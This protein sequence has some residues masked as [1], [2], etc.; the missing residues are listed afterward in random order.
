M[1]AKQWFYFFFFCHCLNQTESWPENIQWSLANIHQWHLSPNVAFM[2]YLTDNLAEYNY[3]G[4]IL[5][6]FVDLVWASTQRTDARQNLLNQRMFWG[7]PLDKTS[8][9][10]LCYDHIWRIVKNAVVQIS[11]LMIFPISVIY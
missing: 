7:R 10:I 8:H 3:W 5:K 1:D 2:S 4:E 9:F 6:W 11:L